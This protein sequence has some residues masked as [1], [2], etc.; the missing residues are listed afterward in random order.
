MLRQVNGDECKETEKILRAEQALEF[1][2]VGAEVMCGERPR[3]GG[4]GELEEGRAP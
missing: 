2:G 4:P 3:G 1:L